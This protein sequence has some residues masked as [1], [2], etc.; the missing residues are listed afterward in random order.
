MNKRSALTQLT[1]VVDSLNGIQRDEI[2]IAG[3][4]A[5]LLNGLCDEVNDIDVYS[6]VRP[7]AAVSWTGK[8]KQGKI[9]K[10]TEYLPE[11]K[12]I[13]LQDID[14]HLVENF[15][16]Y[17]TFTH[18]KFRVLNKVG[19]LMF[20]IDIGREKDLKDIN[21]LKEYWCKLTPLYKQRLNKLLEKFS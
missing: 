10:A 5:A 6:G 18:R 11:C 15:D 9:L 16:I 12:V 17:P 2:V 13:P 20:R 7:F 1:Q 8:A 19:L 21:A 14:F 3:S 4:L